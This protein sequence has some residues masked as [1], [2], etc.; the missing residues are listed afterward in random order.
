MQCLGFNYKEAIGSPL[1]EACANSITK[2]LKKTTVY[3]KLDNL[4][5]HYPK[6][7]HLLQ[8]MAVST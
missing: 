1:T 4:I 7:K 6:S 5:F 8:K 3:K 2:K